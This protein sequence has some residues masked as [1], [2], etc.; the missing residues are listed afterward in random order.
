MVKDDWLHLG[1]DVEGI[2]VSDRW[3][4][5]DGRGLVRDYINALPPELLRG[6]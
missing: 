6:R 2:G 3:S 4:N 5:A 1:H